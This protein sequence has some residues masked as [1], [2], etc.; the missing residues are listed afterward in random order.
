[1]INRFKAWLKSGSRQPHDNA[2]ELK[3]KLFDTSPLAQDIIT[4]DGTFLEVNIAYCALHGMAR[5]DLLGKT[6]YMPGLPHTSS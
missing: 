4:D 5:S 2:G 6:P 1:M 3:T